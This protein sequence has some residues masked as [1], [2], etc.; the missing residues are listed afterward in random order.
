MT[1]ELTLMGLLG[2]LLIAVA[3]GINVLRESDRQ[4]Q[5]QLDLRV[6]AVLDGMDRFAENCA[7]CHGA[8]GEGLGVYR[9]LNQEF[10][11]KKDP[12][13]LFTVIR[14]G[15]YATEMAAF[16]LDEGGNLTPGQIDELVAMLQYGS[17]DAIAARVEALGLTPTEADVQA[18]MRSVEVAAVGQQAADPAAL[19]AA[20]QLFADNCVECH[21]DQGQGTADA[22]QLNNAYVRGM[23]DTQLH[24]II[25]SGVRNTK[26]EGFE[27][28]LTGEEIA[29]LILLLHNW[30]AA[31]GRMEGGES[32]E[33]Q[34]ASEAEIAAVTQSG[35]ELF[36]T[37]CA[38]CHGVRG[39]GGAIAPSLNDIPRLPFDF[40]VSRVRGGQN[41]MPPFPEANLSNAQL[42]VLIDYA[43]T[44]VIG[45]G[46]PV[47]TAAEI[48]T[49][50]ALYIA[51]CA[52]CHGPAGEGVPDKGPALVIMPPMRASEIVNFTRVGSSL[53]PAIPPGVVSDADLRLIVAYILSR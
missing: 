26:M 5:A 31:T 24:S 37:W 12:H 46:L 18:A 17:W 30:G 32:A 41:A 39:E 36:E 40:I 33:T 19:P 52:E 53:T 8:A 38:P 22:P 42:A 44:S 49:G 34:L 15:R 16:A 9:A 2:T 11:V 48:E 10:I 27:S 25:A 35:Q 13:D 21:G 47:F 7:I 6:A 4:A 3:M 51:G 14:Y 28:R 1:R 50:R 29:A 23:S 43:Q 45:A 20:L